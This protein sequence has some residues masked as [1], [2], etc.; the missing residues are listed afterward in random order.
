MMENAGLFGPRVDVG[1]IDDFCK[2]L[3]WW[4]ALVRFTRMRLWWCSSSAESDLV[5]QHGGTQEVR[6]G[7]NL[8]QQLRGSRRLRSGSPGRS[9]RGWY[10]MRLP[11]SSG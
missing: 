11:W 2:G 4:L 6:N 8:T 3:V 7:G 9:G 10:R 1:T 5:A